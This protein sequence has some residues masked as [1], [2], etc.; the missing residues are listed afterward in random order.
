MVESIAESRTV[1]TALS[2]A[3]IAVCFGKLWTILRRRDNDFNIK[4][5]GPAQNEASDNQGRSCE[6]RDIQ[7]NAISTSTKSTNRRS[8]A[9]DEGVSLESLDCIH[10][11]HDKFSTDISLSRLMLDHV[12]SSTKVYVEKAES[13]QSSGYATESSEEGRQDEAPHYNKSHNK[14]STSFMKRGLPNMT[15]NTNDVN[16]V[17]FGLALFFIPL[18]PA[19]NLLFYVG[20][21]VAERVLYLPSAGFCVIVVCWWQNAVD[22]LRTYQRSRLFQQR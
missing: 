11:D 4:C 21:V 15:R 7:N 12:K 13:T 20:F 2:Y 17:L 6:D 16:V 5:L 14:Q 8:S 1:C 9:V 3:V 19:T 10:P 18:L 22:C